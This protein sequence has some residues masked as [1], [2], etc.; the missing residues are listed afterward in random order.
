MSKRTL[1]AAL[2]VASLAFVSAATPA[3]FAQGPVAYGAG[4]ID[5]QWHTI[6]PNA[7][8]WYFFNRP[9]DQTAVTLSLVNGVTLG[10]AF[11]VFAPGKTDQPIGRGTS[12]NVDCNG[13]KCPSSDLTWTG[14]ANSPGQYSVQVIN[15]GSNVVSYLLT[16]TGGSPTP[17]PG[18][19]YFPYGVPYVPPYVAPYPVVPYVPPNVAPYVPP[20]VLPPYY[21]PGN[22]S[23]YR[24]FC[25]PAY[26]NMPNNYV[27]WYCR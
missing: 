12:S 27:P 13:S 16:L 8:Q 7:T 6:G 22:V 24:Q 14:G 15:N 26:F 23:P 21:G 11:N 3:A 25:P 20:Y 5:N 10:L 9:N 17:V 18:N 1:V 2:I 19:P 4:Y